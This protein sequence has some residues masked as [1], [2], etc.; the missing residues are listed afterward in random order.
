MTTTAAHLP[1]VTDATFA[2]E[3]LDAGGTTAVVF[4]AQWC[5]PCRVYDPIAATVAAELGADIRFAHVDTDAN[6]ATTVRYAVRNLPTTIFFRGGEPVGQ[7]IGAVP[8][9]RLRAAVAQVLAGRG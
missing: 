1:E 5:G 8:K 6:P 4:G 2:A 3:V 9:D 7:V